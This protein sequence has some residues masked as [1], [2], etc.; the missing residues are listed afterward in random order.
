MTPAWVQRHKETM[1]CIVV[2][3]YDLWEQAEANS[4]DPLGAQ[5]TLNLERERDLILCS[6]INEKKCVCV[7]LMYQ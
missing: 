3:F 6:E 2:G 7:R 5:K 4:V 1:P